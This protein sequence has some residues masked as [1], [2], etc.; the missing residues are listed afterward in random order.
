MADLCNFDYFWKQ[1]VDATGKLG[2]LPEQKMTGALRMLAYGAGADQCDEVTR[3]GASTA[4]K[5]L[6]KFCAQGEY[7]YR[8]WYLRAPNATDLQ[9]FLHK[10]QQRGFP[11]IIGSIDCMHWKWKNC[12][13]GWPELSQA[14]K[15]AQNDLNVL[16]A[17]NVFARV[18]NRSAPEVAYKVNNSTYSV[19]Y[20]LA[21]GIYPRWQTFVKAISKPKDANEAHFTKMQ[22]S[23]RKDVE[24]CFGI[25]QV[26]WAIL[27]HG[28][29]LFKLE[30]LRTIMISCIILH[31]MIVEDE[32]VE[33]EFEES[34]E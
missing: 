24:R 7:L 17:S 31:N 22:E 33:E 16:G 15:G 13:N 5:C 14:V 32:F 12:P 25:L 9:R 21:N 18:I 29:N 6:K 19:P 4:L 27:R 1:K 11:G 2:L 26:R 23:Y 34:C 20:Y 28:A 30:D 8:G 10:G 3:M